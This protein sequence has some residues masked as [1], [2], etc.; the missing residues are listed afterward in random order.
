MN[1]HA[2]S[3]GHAVGS[4]GRAPQISDTCRR[5]LTAVG[6]AYGAQQR[7]REWSGC[8]LTRTP[9]IASGRLGLTELFCFEVI[10][11]PD[12]LASDSSRSEYY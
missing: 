4:R 6:T 3:S 11:F 10:L 9:R 2:V 7:V 1:N 12:C 5:E 8:R